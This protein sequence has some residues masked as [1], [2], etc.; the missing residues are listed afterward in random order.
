MKSVKPETSQKYWSGYF[1]N[2]DIDFASVYKRKNYMYKDRKMAEFNFKLIHNILPCNMNL[3]K[4]KKK[5]YNTCTICNVIE[6]IPHMLYECAYAKTIWDKL[7]IN[8]TVMI[9]ASE[10]ILGSGSSDND[11]MITTFIS[12]FIYKTWLK[13]SFDNCPRDIKTAIMLLKCYL[14]RVYETYLHLKCN[15]LCQEL[16]RVIDTL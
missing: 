1:A 14:K 8:R 9:T 6:D 11:I 10:V 7:N 5:T 3:H 2:V 13:N 4:W 12:Y 15:S 16:K